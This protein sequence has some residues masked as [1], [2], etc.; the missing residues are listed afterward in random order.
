MS[1][2]HHGDPIVI[3]RVEAFVVRLDADGHTTRAPAVYRTIFDRG[4]LYA[5][6]VETVFVR[7]EST[8]GVVGWGEALAPAGPRAT[9]AV[10]EDILRPLLLG[11]D[12]SRVRFLHA[13]LQESM[14]E[15]G[16]LG[17]FQ[18]DGIAGVD[19][20]LWDL[21]GRSRGLSVADLLGGAFRTR[22]PTY[23]SSI[24][25]DSD[26]ERAQTILEL[27]AQGAT[28]FKLHFGHGVAADLASF[29]RI[30]S[31]VPT[32]D[33]AVD[34]H[35]VYTLPQAVDLARGLAE[36]HAWFLESALPPEN[37]DD[38]ARLADK[39]D[40]AL[41][42]GEAMRNRYEA[43][44]WIA[45]NA[46]QIY[47]PD[48]GRTGITEGSNIATIA[49]AAS[50]QV[51]PHHSLALGPA[52]A[53]GLHVAATAQAMPSFEYQITAVRNANSLLAE[54]LEV[55]AGHMVLPAGPGLGVEPLEAE[56]RAAAQGPR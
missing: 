7:V 6:V 35:G 15:R 18:A 43:S 1:A 21:L 2:E 4:T 9:A 32:G 52:L 19:I 54:P 41:A 53:A 23:V 27:Q 12:A 29:D 24:T 55:H 39:V 48:V 10:I 56:I 30:R 16:H 5:D 17:G 45:R 11:Q 28:R 47:Q 25:G 44:A 40:L 34:V 14:R 8:D 49:S 46:L 3:S 31:L 37:L 36:R 20:A 42:A 50:R 33:F 51:M 22:V 38:F 26:D 13:R